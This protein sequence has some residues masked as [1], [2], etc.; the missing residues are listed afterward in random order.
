MKI[1]IEGE[2]VN[3]IIAFALQVRSDLE[4]KQNF[5][6]KLDEMM[7][8]TFEKEKMIIGADLNG[9]LDRGN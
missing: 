8:S 3:M 9:H 4:E 2:I 6:N 7:R 1:E 5:C